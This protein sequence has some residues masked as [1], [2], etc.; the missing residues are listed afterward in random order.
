MKTARN[1]IGVR[2]DRL[3]VETRHGSLVS[4]CGSSYPMWFCRC[5]CGRTTIVRGQHLRDGRI[6]SCG[7]LLVESGRTA[8]LRHGYTAGGRKS[9]E[10]NA[11]S[12]AKHRCNNSSDPRYATYGARGIR[13]CE[14]WSQSFAAF[15]RDMGPCPVDCSLDRRDNDGNYEPGNAR[16]A[17]RAEQTN[18][19][20]DSRFVELNGK[21]LTVAE[22]SQRVGLSQALVFSRLYKGWSVERALGLSA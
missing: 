3:V 20:T 4:P 19:R 18:N 12:H 14:E 2:F 13:M 11:W 22:A 21:R 16:W 1:L 5:D 8:N 7:C 10:H 15:I 9:R 17:T 6:K